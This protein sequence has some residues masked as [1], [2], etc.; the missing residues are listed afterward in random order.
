MDNQQE[1]RRTL[2]VHISGD[3]VAAAQSA[4]TQQSLDFRA[5][6]YLE[7]FSQILMQMVIAV[8]FKVLM[9]CLMQAV[10]ASFSSCAW[11]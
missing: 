9:F 1:N 3:P 2:K 6:H 5:Q 10:I 7:L 11:L 8:D 4:G